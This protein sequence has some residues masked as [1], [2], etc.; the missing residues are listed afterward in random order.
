MVHSMGKKLREA[1]RTELYT[2]KTTNELIVLMFYVLVHCCRRSEFIPKIMA[3]DCEIQAVL[4]TLIERT[5]T[6]IESTL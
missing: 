6:N 5:S 3:M 2:E 1:Y 4:M